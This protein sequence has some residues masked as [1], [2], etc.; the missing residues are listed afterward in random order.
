MSPIPA[1]TPVAIGAAVV[2]Q[3]EDDPA[4]ALGVLELIVRAARAAAV[5][6][7]AP[8]VLARSG[9]VGALQGS[10]S[11]ANPAGFV[12]ERVGDPTAHT[13]LVPIGVPQQAVVT[14][15]VRA[16]ASG[17]CDVALAVGGE[18]MDRARRATRAGIEVGEP[19]VEGAPEERLEPPPFEVAP[20]ERQVGLG[21]PVETYALLESAYAAAQGWTPSGH[22][23]RLGALCAAMADVARA[24]PWAWDPSAPSA[25]EIVTPTAANRMIATPYTKRMCSQWHVD[26][27]S[28]VLVC[29]YEVARRLGIREDRMV[30][31]HAAT[32]SLH[33]IPVVERAELG[34]SVG[35]RRGRRARARS[36][37]SAASTTSSTSSCTAASPWRCRCMRAPWDSRPTACR[38]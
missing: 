24:N 8:E 12:A 3:R 23:E 35:A 38:R 14:E 7:G 15:A 18:A 37:P 30:F 21:A 17:R 31:P 2:R 9:W 10:W 28:A 27:A 29:A 5:D 32:V 13:V 1:R 6:S 11:V 19:P 4:C 34:D 26:L 33:T 36:S 25:D 22:R 16:V 20:V